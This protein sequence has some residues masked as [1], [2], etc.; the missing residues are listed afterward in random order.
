MFRCL[1]HQPALQRLVAAE[2]ALAEKLAPD[3]EFTKAEVVWAARYE[4]ARRPYR[5]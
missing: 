3:L 4:M 2:P 5:P 1:F